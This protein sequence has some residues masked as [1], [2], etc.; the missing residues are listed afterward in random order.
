MSHYCNAAAMYMSQDCLSVILIKTYVR[1]LSE[2]ALRED[3]IWAKILVFD[4]KINIENMFLKFF[5]SDT[6]VIMMVAKP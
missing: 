4:R 1:L 2:A 3:I 6:T 5:N